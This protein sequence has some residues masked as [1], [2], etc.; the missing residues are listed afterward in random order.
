MGIITKVNDD[1]TLV[2]IDGEKSLIKYGKWIGK[3]ANELRGTNLLVQS[4]CKPL[5]IKDPTGN[6]TV[7]R[8]PMVGNTN[9]TMN[10]GNKLIPGTAVTLMETTIDELI[11]S[12]GDTIKLVRK[13]LTTEPAAYLLVH[14]GGR[15]LGI[16]TRLEEVHKQLVREA[17]GVPFICV[18]TLGEYGFKE[19]SANTC[20]GLMLSFTGFGKE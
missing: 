19:H 7:I 18:F 13:G 20:G 3:S 14:G 17:M 15:K 16:G 12:T 4:I 8:H 9:D 1:R 5:G 11:S 2:S 6:L 10:L